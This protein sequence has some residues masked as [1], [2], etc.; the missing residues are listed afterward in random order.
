MKRKALSLRR[1]Q[2][3]RPIPKGV[4]IL[5]GTFLVL[6]M[7][8]VARSVQ[9]HSALIAW[10]NSLADG[11]TATAWPP[12]NATWPPLPKPPATATRAFTSDWQGPYAFAALNSESF[13]F[14]PCYCGCRREGHQ[15]VLACYVNGFAPDGVPMWSDHAFTCETCVN[16]VREVLL[17]SRQSTSLRSIRA[18]IDEHHGGLLARPTDTPLPK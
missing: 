3:T 10:R 16:I 6:L 8:L 9:H 7:L 12:W 2:P 4:W 14:I 1:R 11:G 15:S 5:L 18:S 17:M 13:R